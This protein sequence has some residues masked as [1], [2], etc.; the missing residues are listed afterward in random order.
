[1]AKKPSGKGCRTIL[2]RFCYSAGAERAQIQILGHVPI[3]TTERSL[4]CNR[5]SA[6]NERIGIETRE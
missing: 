3:L 6:V 5:R 4:V 2:A 1:M